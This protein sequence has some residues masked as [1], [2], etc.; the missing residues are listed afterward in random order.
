MANDELCA[1]L[2][3]KRR[4][5]KLYNERSTWLH[6]AHQTLDAAVFAAYG[7]DV[8]RARNWHNEIPPGRPR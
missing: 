3:Q 7:W 8:W 4:L 2:L 5:T 6:L 1:K